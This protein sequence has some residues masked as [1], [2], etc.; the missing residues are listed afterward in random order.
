[1]NEK[2][3]IIVI[4]AVILV[5]ISSLIIVLHKNQPAGH[6][7]ITGVELG[8]AGTVINNYTVNFPK[9]VNTHSVFTINITFNKNITLTS[10]YITTL[11]FKIT[12]WKYE[13][14]NYVKN[15]NNSG[16]FVGSIM[17][18]KGILTLYIESPI[19]KY[20]GNLV[21]HIVGKV[22]VSVIY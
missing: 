1:M 10:V 6:D 17:D 12:K 15:M 19:N 7:N 8:S 11:G 2:M 18:Y 4:I 20:N 3:K 21:L 14:G 22:P 5:L 9:K 16:G 13:Y